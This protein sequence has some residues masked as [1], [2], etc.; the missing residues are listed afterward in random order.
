MVR[1]LV[2]S[3]ASVLLIALSSSA[4][5]QTI[6]NPVQG[7]TYGRSS[8]IATR[9]R[10]NNADETYTVKL[11]NPSGS[12]ANEENVVTGENPFVWSYTFPAPTNG[13]CP[14]GEWKVELWGGNPNQKLA[15]VTFTISDSSCPS[16]PP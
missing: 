13:W 9:G 16:C 15:T 5:A 6:D 1:R 2:I 14:C 12:I 11:I 3:V 10:G 4:H 8:N 7:S